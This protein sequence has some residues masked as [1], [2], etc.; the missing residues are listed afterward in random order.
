MNVPEVTVSDLKAL[1]DNGSGPHLLDVRRPDE[2]ELANIGGSHIILDQLPTRLEE[3]EAYKEKSLVVYCRSGARSSRAVQ[4]LIHH[5]FSDV[6]NLKG[7]MIAWGREIDP[8]L[9]SF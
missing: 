7:G 1:M 3:L 6:K 4:F 9:P 5:G 8:S 2:R